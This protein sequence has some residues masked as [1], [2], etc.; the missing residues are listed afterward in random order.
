MFF[1]EFV[2]FFFFRILKI[3]YKRSFRLMYFVCW[4]L[5]HM[6]CDMFFPKCL[7]LSS[8][9]VSEVV[10]LDFDIL[11]NWME[12]VILDIIRRF[13]SHQ[14]IAAWSLDRNGGVGV[15]DRRLSMTK[16]A[17]A[18]VGCLGAFLLKLTWIKRPLTKM[19]YM[20]H[21]ESI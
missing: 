18:E 15:G 8:V 17:P 9:D 21:T 2:C 14:C 1:S 19:G 3:P 20:I 7:F 5:M 6:M 10:H 16:P 13:K 4:L 11:G 12:L